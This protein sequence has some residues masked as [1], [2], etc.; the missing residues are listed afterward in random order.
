MDLAVIGT[1]TGVGK[2]HV[3]LDLPRQL[4]MHG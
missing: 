4:R 1:D 2:T 3:T